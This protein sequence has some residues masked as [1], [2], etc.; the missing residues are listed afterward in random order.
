MSFFNLRLRI[1]GWKFGLARRNMTTVARIPRAACG[2]AVVVPILNQHTLDV[3]ALAE[4]ARDR[5][6]RPWSGI[7][8]AKLRCPL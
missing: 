8:L 6:R 5:R 2:Y 4:T 7:D 1:N 3:Q